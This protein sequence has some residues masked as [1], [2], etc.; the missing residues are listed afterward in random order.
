V[1]DAFG[2]RVDYLRISV[3]DRCNMRC[4][5]CMPAEGL[6][7]FDRE[8]VLSYEEIT[9]F[10]REVAVPLGVSRL[11]LT[12]GEPLVRR[13]LHQL[14]GQLAALPG[15]TDLALT[16]N[17]VLLAGQA[18]A[19]RAAGVTRVN[20]SLDSLQPDRFRHITRGADLA[21]VWAG[22]AAAEQAGFSP[23]KLNCVVMRG[24]NEDEVAAFAALTLEHPWHV[25]FIEFMPVGDHA[26]FEQVGYVPTSEVLARIRE[27]HD[28][29]PL[30]APEVAGN[31]PARYWRVP[32]A[33][34]AIGVIS[35][36]SH[37]F[38]DACNR[39]RLTSDGKL[40]H[41]LLS[42][43]E[44]DVRALLRGGVSAAEIRASVVADLQ[45]K[46]ERHEGAAGIASHLRSMSQ[47]GG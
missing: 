42:D 27:R 13:D 32:G 46:R 7:Y 16:T 33:P 24:F 19:L 6:D 25:R 29:V 39:V 23:L 5:Y 34:G 44:L 17:G 2:R 38:C 1:Q 37:D 30:A 40:R 45:R 21:R 15:I 28:V 20:V 26:L 22:I 35:Q 8:D 3:T 18:E 4:H 10:V 14:A 31:G 12:G 36:M 11:R 41:C 47:I 43:H 9:A